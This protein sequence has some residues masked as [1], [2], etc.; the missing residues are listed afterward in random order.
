MSAADDLAKLEEALASGAKKVKYQDK[1]VE[2]QT[3]ED[4]LRYR[5]ILIAKLQP[6][7]RATYSVKAPGYN[8]GF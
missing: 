7:G 3:T 4:M 5:K 2:Y 6:G 1:E 8:G